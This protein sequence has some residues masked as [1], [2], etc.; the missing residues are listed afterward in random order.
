MIATTTSEQTALSKY[1]ERLLELHRLIAAGKCDTDEADRVRDTMDAPWRK[2]TQDQIKLV[3]GL[4][5]DLYTIGAERKSPD[6]IEADVASATDA[7][8]EELRWGDLLDILREH[9]G[10]LPPDGV[11]FVRGICWFEL[12]QPEVAI[13]FLREATRLNPGEPV[14]GY[15]LH[16]LLKT[17]QRGNRE[18]NFHEVRDSRAISTMLLRATA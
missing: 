12:Q 9:E 18:S 2:L 3:R 14:Y 10:K 5:A 13:E 4:S 8:F 11:A 7:A 15:C 17:H 1:C 16:I 6:S